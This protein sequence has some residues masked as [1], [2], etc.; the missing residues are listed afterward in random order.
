MRK[1]ISE[2]L[3]NDV[4]DPRIPLMTSVVEVKM[5]NDL[6]HAKVFLSVLADEKG[7]QDLK[8]AITSAS[9]FI[10]REVSQRINLRVAP[11]I[12]F[13]IDESI[14][15]GMNLMRLIDETIREDSTRE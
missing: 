3:R 15:K 1:I 11:D 4:K 5:S 13:V 10:R 12:Q 2:I 8:E 9:G 14:E 6:S 7:K